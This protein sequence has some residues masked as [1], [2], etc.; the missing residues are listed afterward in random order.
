WLLGR[1]PAAELPVGLR[2][3]HDHGRLHGWECGPHGAAERGRRQPQ[4]DQHDHP[5][6]RQPDA[7][8]LP[9][10]RLTRTTSPSKEGTMADDQ[11]D[12]DTR[13]RLVRVEESQKRIEEKIDMFVSRSVSENVE[14]KSRISALE[15]WRYGTGAAIVAG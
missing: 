5:A 8:L 12:R 7:L 15:K 3:G 6:G 10:H 14:L 4:R 9:A 13:E 2:P 11:I 1:E